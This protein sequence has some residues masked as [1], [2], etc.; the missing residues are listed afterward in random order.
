MRYEDL[1]LKTKDRRHIAVEFVSNVYEAGD[2]KVIQCNVRDINRRKQ[3]EATSSLLAAIV[4][5]SDDAIYAKDLNNLITSWNQGAEKIFGYTAGEMIGTSILR[6]IPA[7]RQE[8]E[9]EIL[10]KIQLGENLTQIET[11]RQTKDG[12]IIDVSVTASPIKDA[13]GKVI[14]VS[15]VLHDISERKEQEGQLLWKTTLLEA[16]LEASIDGILVVGN[17]GE[18]IIQNRRI[19]ELWKMPPQIVAAKDSAAQLAFV[20]SQVKNPEQFAA[21]V[22]HLYAHPDENSRDEVELIDGTILDRYPAPVRDAA[23]KHYGRIWSFRDLTERRKMEQQFQKAQKMESIGLLAGGIAHDF[24][25]IL[26]AIVGN[27]YLAKLTAAEQPEILAHLENV[28]AASVRA[29]E[30]VKQIL[31]FSRQTKPEREPLK[32]N[33]VVME[34]L[35]LL[36]ASLPASIRIQTE[37]AET[38]IVLA[39][40]TAVHQMMMNLATN[41]WHAMRDQPGTLKVEMNVL[42]LDE[43]FAKTRPDLHPGS[44]V[45]LSVSDTGCGMDRHTLEHIFEPFFTT[46]G[47]GEGTGLGLAV[48]HGIMKSHDGGVSVYSQPGKGTRF[49]LYFPVMAT[50][51]MVR[52]IEAAPIPRGHGEHIL[53][54]D[55]EEALV[56]VG[57]KMLEHLGYVVTAKSSPLEAITLVRDQP[58]AFDL[59]ITDLTMPGLDGVAFGRRLL[60]IQPRLAIILTTGY[61]GRMT[62][63]K[64]R[65][66][67]FRELLSKPCTARVLAETVQRVLHPPAAIKK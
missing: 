55:D 15:K 42:D 7:D 48:V 25:N 2:Q 30:L 6:L 35:N 59:V 16:Q 19:A 34:V 20:T 4:E 32:L 43:D 5:S 33:Q 1:P 28:S 12:R 60:Q 66:L 51:V 24:N 23:G 3:A 61:S 45:Q 62:A 37:L 29:T 54:V 44:Y 11:L 65:K 41:A 10:E 49:N 52:E 22:S 17:Q 13:G 47:V 67:G 63:E 18:Q 50:E 26:S 46:K 8:E 56:Q 9:H 53:F 64:V 21:R 40:A 57:K 38:P 27:L 58:E 36:R 39:N 31:T 14:G